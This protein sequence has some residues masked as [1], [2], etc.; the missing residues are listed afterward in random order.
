MLLKS[1]EGYK[2]ELYRIYS[3]HVFI[4]YIT[5]AS[6]RRYMPDLFDG[7]FGHPVNQASD[8]TA[9]PAVA[10]K[11]TRQ[12]PGSDQSASFLFCDSWCAFYDRYICIP[13]IHIYIYISYIYIYHI[14]ISYIYIIYIYHIY[15]SYI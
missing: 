13:L 15:I 11:R 12:E 9:T 3:M 5:W 4:C 8:S 6:I 10:K 7:L 14:Y 2:K 1:W